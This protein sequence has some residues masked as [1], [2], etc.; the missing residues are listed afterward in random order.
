M[1]NTVGGT[2]TEFS[3]SSFPSSSSAFSSFYIVF[4][5]LYVFFI[6]LLEFGSGFVLP[7]FYSLFFLLSFFFGGGGGDVLID[8]VLNQHK[9]S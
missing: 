5:K 3:S 4:R 6:F 2:V 7:I 8:I 9:G 1:L